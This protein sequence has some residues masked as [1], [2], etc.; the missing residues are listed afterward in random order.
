VRFHGKK[1]FPLTWLLLWERVDN[2][3]ELIPKEES[4]DAKKGN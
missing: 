3:D 1:H 4:E 2:S